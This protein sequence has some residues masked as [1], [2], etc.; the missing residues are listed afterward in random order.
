LGARA[1]TEDARA[2]RRALVEELRAIEESWLRVRTGLAALGPGERLPGLHLLVK[3]AGR[4]MLLPADRVGEIARI[5]ACE[6]IP[7]TAPWVLGSFVWR[8]QPAVAV[9]LATRLGGAPAVGLER[10]MIVLDGAP[11]VAL[12][13]EDVLGLVEDPILAEADG[14]G[15]A[16]P[17]VG[18][19]RLDEEAVAIVAPEV[20]EREVR[21]RA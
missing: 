2:R 12:V 8:G 20:V 17:V 15:G 4:R 11:A 9:D 16:A 21:E 13:V 7:G 6:P 14:G 1:A 3:V 5:V 19:C 10:A 18:A